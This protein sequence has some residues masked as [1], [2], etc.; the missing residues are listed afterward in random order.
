MHF[1]GSA[2]F[3]PPR[4]SLGAKGRPSAAAQRARPNQ[5]CCATGRSMKLAASPLRNTRCVAL[6]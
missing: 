1:S 4:Q 5:G 6:W 2:T 3:R